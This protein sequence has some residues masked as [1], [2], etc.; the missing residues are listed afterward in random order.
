M[1]LIHSVGAVENNKMIVN[2]FVLCI[3]EE[4][5][6]LVYRLRKNNGL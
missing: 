4:K 6:A 5:P 1:F 2:G 3:K